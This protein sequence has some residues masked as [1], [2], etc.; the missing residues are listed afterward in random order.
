MRRLR[1]DP[2]PL[3]TQQRIL[4]AAIRAPSSGNS[5]DWRFLLIDDPAMKASL[6]P[7]Y[8]DG[9]ARMWHGSYADRIK[10]AA[11]EPDAD[12]SVALHRFIRSVQHLADHFE[13]CPLFLFGFAREE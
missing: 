2:I 5:Q 1:A 6:G 3:E 7:L 13:E 9:V 4:D 11:A 10:R 8:R 12:E